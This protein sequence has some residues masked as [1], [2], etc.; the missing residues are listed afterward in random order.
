MP[1]AATDLTER[2]W[3]F[4]EGG[5]GGGG[6]RRIATCWSRLSLGRGAGAF[7]RTET[8]IRA[9]K[10]DGE[11]TGAKSAFLL[12]LGAW[13]YPPSS[14]HGRHSGKAARPR[15]S[16]LFSATRYIDTRQPKSHGMPTYTPHMTPSHAQILMGKKT[17]KKVRDVTTLP[18]LREREQFTRERLHMGDGNILHMH[19]AKLALPDY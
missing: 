2:R 1:R 10:P 9:C 15:H 14:T 6:A 16:R 13:F 3:M 17:S 12:S 5:W 7:S 18:R 4:F 8:E 19:T 11:S